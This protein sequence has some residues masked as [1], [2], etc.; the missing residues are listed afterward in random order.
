MFYLSQ[1]LFI[2]AAKYKFTSLWLEFV[3]KKVPLG[4]VLQEL[5][6]QLAKVVVWFNL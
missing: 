2:V 3:T 1:K 6:N 4:K 5:R